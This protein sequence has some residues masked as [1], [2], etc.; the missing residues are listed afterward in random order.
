MID[1]LIGSILEKENPTVAGLDPTLEMV[2][3]FLKEKYFAESGMTTEA[4][5]RIFAEFNKNIIDHICDIVPAVKPQIAM[6]EKFGIEGLKAYNET[7]AYAHSKGLLVIG[8]IKRGDISSTAAAYAAHLEG[9][10]IGERQVET[11][12]EDAVTLNPYMGSD[13]IRPFVEICAKQPKGIFLLVKTSNPS[14]SEMQDLVLADGRR[15]YEAAGQLVEAWGAEAI[16]SRG[17]S[18]VGT[19]VGATHKEEGTRLRKQMPHTFFL[20]PGYGA[21]GGTADD[22]AGFF[23]K[24][25]IGAIVNSSRGITAAYKKDE[26]F[27]EHQYA[28]AARTAALRM[29]DDL[30]RVL[31]G[32][33]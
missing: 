12:A 22:I 14:S 31:Q 6:Y 20:V 33:R 24:D 19:V 10:Q 25:G 27:S 13:G 30:Q 23:D 8:D 5:G 7:C 1:R 16:G 2:P 17:Y 4:V 15:V 3:E 11:W 9:A 26:S 18:N 21:Q 28:E 32:G 29:R